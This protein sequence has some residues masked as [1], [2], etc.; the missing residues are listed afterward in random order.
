VPWGGYITSDSD[1]VDDATA[2]HHYTN[3]SA[4]ASCLAVRDG[5]D[6]IDSGNTYYDH[7]LDGVKQGLCTMSDIDTALTNTLRLRFELGL[8]DPP[9]GQPLTKLGTQ[10]VGTEESA[11]LNLRATA[12]SLVLLKNDNVTRAATATAITTTVAAVA[13]VADGA[14]STSAPLLPLAKG[15]H[16]SVIGPHANASRNLLQ[17]DTGQICG[18]DRTFDCVESPYAA[19]KRLNEQGGGG[20]TTLA[21][22]CD[23][24]DANISTA[25]L[26]EEAIAAA[27]AADVVV[28]AIGISQCGCMGITDTYMGGTRTNAHGCATSVVPP[29]APWG[30]CWDHK[31]VTAG[32]YIGAEAHDRILID[33]PPVQRAFAAA[34][35]AAIGPTKPVVLLL[36]NGGSVDMG[37][38]L[39]WSTSAIEAFYPGTDG[40]GVIANSIFGEGR[41]FNRFGRM[42]YTTYPASFVA[43]TPMVEHDM[44]V[45]PGRTHQFYTGEAVLP[46]GWGLSFSNFEFAIDA[47]SSSATGTSTASTST[48]STSTASATTPVTI[49]TDGSA[50]TT[51][52]LVVTN[53][54]PFVGDAIMLAF[55]V[56]VSLPTQPESKLIQR[57]FD[58]SRVADLAVGASATIEVKLGAEVLSLY[59]VATG[60]I[61]SV[62]GQY[63]VWL[64]KGGDGGDVKVKLVVEGT[65]RVIER[66]PN[67]D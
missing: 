63:E 1:S 37:Q 57:L 29:Y 23:L 11:M 36:L 34:V 33:L 6:D 67:A 65:Q 18:G 51:V 21:V 39:A 54:G 9:A 42:P 31:E 45:A 3:S 8:F 24:I 56:P 2:I 44:S 40:A 66:F 30:N 14:A 15:Q 43:E 5:G 16:I 59:D 26:R 60:D 48:A 13:A 20:S 46:F 22:G 41:D 55:L 62:P 25:G 61:V 47:S 12:A 35:R 7:L 27:V 64:R 49:R 28:L 53:H 52:K 19:I 58:F 4:N 38:E 17:V 32:Q 50:D 10:D